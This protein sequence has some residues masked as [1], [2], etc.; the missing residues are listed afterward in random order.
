METTIKV[1]LKWWH[2]SQNNSGGYFIDNDVVSHDVFI[3]ARNAEEAEAKAAKIFEPYSAYCGC[4]GERWC[5][6]CYEDEGTDNPEKNG[7]P[8]SVTTKDMFNKTYILH[9]FDGRVEKG[10]YQ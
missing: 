9:H 4:C 6:S 1:N 2:F 10:E 8:L 7:K 5:T 3:Q